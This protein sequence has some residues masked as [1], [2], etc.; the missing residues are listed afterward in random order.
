MN[1]F[2]DKLTPEGWTPKEWEEHYREALANKTVTLMKTN[3]TTATTTN[4]TVETSTTISR[5]IDP[6]GQTSTKILVSVAAGRI[7]ATRFI[8]YNTDGTLCGHLPIL[9]SKYL[10]PEFNKIVP[11]SKDVYFVFGGRTM[12]KT[13]SGT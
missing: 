6:P 11:F 13:T 10:R 4:T 1:N 12:N 2:A 3:S 9:Q 7:N 5:A 8:V